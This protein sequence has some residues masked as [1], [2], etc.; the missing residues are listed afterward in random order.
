MRATLDVARATPTSARRRRERRI[1][2]FFRHEQVAI[3]MAVVTA[4]HHSAQRCCTIATQTVDSPSV[5]EYVAP[6]PAVT[7]AAPAPVD[8]YVAPSPAVT[9]A[10]PAP[11]IGYVAPAPSVTYAAPASVFEYVAPAPVLE[12]IAPEPAVSFVAPSQQLRPAYTA[13]TTGVNLDASV[14]GS[15]SQVVGSLPHGE[16]FAVPVFNQVHQEQLAGGEIPENLVEIPVVQELFPAGEATEKFAT[17]PVVHEQ[18]ILGVRPDPLAE[19][20]HWFIPGLEAL[21]PDD[22]GAPSLSL[23]S[24][25]D[26]AAEEVDSSSLRFLT[27]SALEA[28]R[29]EEEE[30]KEK[31]RKVVVEVLARAQERVRDGLP[32]SSAE[33]AAWRQWSG[34]PPQQEKRRKRKEK[35]ADASLSASSPWCPRSSSTA[36]VARSW[37]SL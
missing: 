14:E 28:R 31:K 36:A 37:F 4:Q 26:R 21:C 13:D 10:A 34:L 18:V 8:G 23:P 17:I 2:S 29:R 16:M 22:D 33:D 25:A 12:Y 5:I 30:E 9:Y 7:Y 11:V 15:A 27:A 3:K 35:E 20:R 19:P 24:L 1:R 32:L 6:A